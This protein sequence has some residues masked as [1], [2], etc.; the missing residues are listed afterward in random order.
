MKSALR[1][2]LVA[3]RCEIDE[4]ELLAQTSDVVSAIARLVHALQRERGL[5]NVL[6]ASNGRLY[7]PQRLAQIADTLR[8]ERDVRTAFDELETQ[9]RRAGNATRLF[10]RIAAVLPGLHA[11]PLLR[12]RVESLEAD[13]EF[14]TAAYVKLIAGLLA[15]VFEAADGATDPQVSRLLAALFHYMQGKEYA[16]Q[17]RAC[18]AAIFA[19]ARAEPAQRR[20]WLALIAA[21]ERCFQVFQ[22]FAGSELTLEWQRLQPDPERAGLERLRRIA[23][24]CSCDTL[25]LEPGLLAE[26]FDTSSLRIDAMQLIEERLTQALQ[27]QCMAKIEEARAAAQSDRIVYESLPGETGEPAFAYFEQ[28]DAS[29]TASGLPAP[30]V[31]ISLQLERSVLEMLQ[32]QMRR[33][34]A[35]SDELEAV[36]AG[37]N[38]RR[39][40]ERA[41]G[42]LMAR[43]RFSE[44]EA[45]RMLRQTAMRQGRRLVEV[46]ESVLMSADI[47]PEGS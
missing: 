31:P 24:A 1:F 13:V 37:L 45:H 21:Q 47:F 40:V 44:E 30:A 42:L 11:L 35:I 12:R 17:E 5:S 41:K 38:E 22:D 34:Q 23:C 26:W 20:Q 9:S 29:A 39:L 43:R 3:R 18:G 19:A 7:G 8:L 10:S 32:E 25:D 16:G 15:V 33:V 2:L 28:L 4:L 14:V 46:A 36:R 6:L 27:A